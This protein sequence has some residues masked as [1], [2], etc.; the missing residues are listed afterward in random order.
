MNSNDGEIFVEFNNQ[1]AA[2]SRKE[3]IISELDKLLKELQFL[4]NKSP[5]YHVL[6]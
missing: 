4:D 2:L 3:I 5:I 1:K 6:C